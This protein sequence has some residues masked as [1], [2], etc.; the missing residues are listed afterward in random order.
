MAS[1]ARSGAGRSPLLF[2]FLTVF[3]DLLGFGIV[4]PL[5][6]VYSKAYGASELSLGLLFSCFSGMQFLFAPLWGRVSDRFGRRPVLI[7]G[8]VGTAASYALFATADSMLLLFVSRLLAGFFGANISTAQAYIADV[9]TPENRAK[10]MGLIG[11][12]F[13]LGFT[14]GP[15]FGG[16]L[17]SLSP[18]A[19]GWFACGLSL[20]AAAFGWLR[21]PEPARHGGGSRVFHA[22][23]LKRALGEPRISTLMLLTFLSVAA[24]GAFEAMFTRFGLARFPQVFGL[25]SALE[26]AN[27]DQIMAAAP[28]AGRYLA[29]IGVISAVIQGGL[30]RRLVPR[31]GE[32]ALIVAGPLF[33]ASSLFVV[34]LG[35]ALGSWGVVIAGCV[36]LPFGIGTNNPALLGLV[37][38]ASP[39]EEQ[40]A[41][42]GINQSVS[43]LARMTGPPAAGAI[44]QWLGP[45]SPFFAGAVL[46]VLA[47]LVAVGYRARHG[48]SFARTGA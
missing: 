23:Q 48:A 21:L 42:L 41:F 6:P 20:S 46:L 14:L 9:T 47:A 3:I 30:I 26:D 44:F 16:E 32:P 39:P 5:L 10:G 1:P 40:G 7:G 24:F 45:Q 34:G 38:R 28:I 8:L 13:G 35:G 17:T 22:S 25:P 33:L 19:P 12:A 27:L 4:L 43:S 2:V 15:L 18:A 29:V 37:S 36:L 31:F 11:A